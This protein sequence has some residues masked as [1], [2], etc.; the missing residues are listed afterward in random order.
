LAGH[1]SAQ[2]SYGTMSWIM[3]G[4]ALAALPIVPLVLRSMHPAGSGACDPL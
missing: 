4:I 2:Y 3:G 1:L